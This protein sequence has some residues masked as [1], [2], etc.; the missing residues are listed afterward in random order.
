MN[1]LHAFMEFHYQDRDPYKINS[2]N[3]IPKMFT[4]N[5]LH[6]PILIVACNVSLEMTKQSVQLMWAWFFNEL[7]KRTEPIF[8]DFTKTHPTI[9]AKLCSALQCVVSFRMTGYSANLD[10]YFI[11]KTIREA[12]IVVTP[13][14][15]L[16]YE[17]KELT[18]FSAKAELMFEHFAN[19]FQLNLDKVTIFKRVDNKTKFDRGASMLKS[20]ISMFNELFDRCLRARAIANAKQ[21][22]VDFVYTMSESDMLFLCLRTLVAMQCCMWNPITFKIRFGDGVTMETLI[23]DTPGSD[24]KYQMETIVKESLAQK[25]Y[26]C[27]LS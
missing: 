1:S 20:M 13:I 6:C 10:K 8:I 15:L 19:L 5:L 25:V 14:P 27:N 17:T 21:M 23:D 2:D 7:K 18:Y 4:H 26:C 12:F 22:E 11:L 24:K 9:I 3:H 16:R